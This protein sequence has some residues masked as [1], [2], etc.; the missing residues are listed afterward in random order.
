[1]QALDLLAEDFIGVVEVVVS[2]LFSGVQQDVP[3][4][5]SLL[6]PVGVDQ[7][8]GVAH[9]NGFLNELRKNCF[10]AGSEDDGRKSKND[11]AQRRGDAKQPKAAS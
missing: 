6:Q 11:H 10:A 5:L 7:G 8:C 2:G 9:G 4:R 3:D 1:M